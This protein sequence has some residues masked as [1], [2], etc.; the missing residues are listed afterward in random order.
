MHI[1]LLTLVLHGQPQ[2][3]GTYWHGWHWRRHQVVRVVWPSPTSTCYAA[4]GSFC[5]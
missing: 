5:L 1:L 3:H 4:P 2:T